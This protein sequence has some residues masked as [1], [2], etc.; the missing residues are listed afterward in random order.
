MAENKGL[1][2]AA[3]KEAYG[4]LGTIQG[5]AREFGVHGSTVS[6]SLALG[7]RKRDPAMQ[8]AMDAVGTGLVPSMAW[9]KTKATADAP[10]YSIMLRP[11][12]ETPE[13]VADR[14]AERMT[15]II[16]APA[17]PAPAACATDLLNF[18]PLYDVHLGQRVGSFGTAEAVKRL[19]IGVNDVIDRAP[20]AGTMVILNGGDF[21]E[22]TDNSALTQQSKHPLAVDMDFD[23]ISDIA[24]DLTV[25]IID[26][27]LSASDRVVYQGLKGNHDPAIAVALRQALRMRYRDEPRFELLDGLDLFTYSFG[28]NLL[29]GIHGDQKISKAESLT[30]AIAARHAAAWGN[31]RNRELWR[32]HR[33]NQ[34]SVAVPGM[35]LYQVNPICP[36]G[37]YANDN[38]F[39]GQSDIQIVTYKHSGGRCASTVHIFQD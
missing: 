9:I 23:D 29:A 1:G 26:R 17:I 19:R 27:A 12:E 38:L 21:T 16:A 14:I 6:R 18:L 31:S 33:H 35:T 4:R 34:L 39:T 28:N 7:E 30:L 37:R 22:A 20:A 32:G 25:E 2:Y 3:Y 8:G 24:V 10:G 5:V 36:P 13:D 15:N 11:P